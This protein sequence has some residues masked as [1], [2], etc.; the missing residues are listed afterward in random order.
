MAC[1][2]LQAVTKSY[3]GK[4]Q[5]IQPIDLDVADGEFVVM[6][7]PSGCGKSTLLRM[8]AG[9]E[10][11]TSGDIY[12]GD[13]RVTD[14]EPKDRGI[15]MVFQNYAL[16]PHMNVY[17]NMAYGLKI[18][19]F[20]KGHIRQRVEEAARILE[21][22]PLLTRKP[23]E[24]S[25]GQRQRVAMGRAI[26]R[27][28]SVFLFDEPL[29]NLDAKLR[30]QMRLELQ[31]LHRRLKTTSLYV[32]HD[33]VEAMT[34][35]QRVIVMNKGVAEQIGAPA[36]IYRRPASLFVAS[37]I[38]SPA[39][40]LWAGNMSDDGSRFA[41]SPDFAIPLSIPKPQWQ[42]CALTL[43]VRPEHIQLS[44]QAAGGIPLIVDTLELLGADNLAHGKWA[45]QN[46]IVRLS[47]EHC[48]DVGS[49]L[50]L[51]LPETAWH[52]FD[53]QSGLRIEA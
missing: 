52:L 5:V 43:G 53:S 6:V 15:A 44:T 21:L 29:S 25:G 32:T 33:Q 19:G 9:L 39:M 31:Q 34:L 4:T 11:T 50:W 30:V 20:G 37:F 18:R 28:P 16:Y 12:I 10:Q 38:G 48:P 42:G 27:E 7:G 36:E 2:K 46:I 47:H 3:D 51:H 35:A 23:R 13:E 22:Q 14:R 41:L 8:V 45:G 49:T 24:L 40:N 17:D 26:V 1:L